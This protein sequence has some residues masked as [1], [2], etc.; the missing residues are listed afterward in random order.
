MR[1]HNF[2]ST[3]GSLNIVYQ[4]EF[5]T[6]IC[7]DSRKVLKELPA[8]IVQKKLGRRAIGVELNENYCRIIIE[9]IKRETVM[10]LFD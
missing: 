2:D 9:R 3:R 10:P 4:D 7:G 5:I 8:G 1:K 6:L